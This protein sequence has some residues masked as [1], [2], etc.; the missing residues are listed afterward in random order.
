[1][2]ETEIGQYRKPSRCIPF[3]T[4]VVGAQVSGG[5]PVMGILKEVED[6]HRVES[7][8]IRFG[9]KTPNQLIGEYFKNRK[10][11]KLEGDVRKRLKGLENN[12]YVINPIKVSSEVLVEMEGGSRRG[13]VVSS[14]K[15]ELCKEKGFE[16]TILCD[17][18]RVGRESGIHK[19]SVEQY[20]DKLRLKNIE[21]ETGGKRIN[22]EVIK[23]LTDMLLPMLNVTF[24][25]SSIR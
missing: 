6:G 22:R 13:A 3:S 20:G 21:S 7:K 12:T 11:I 19:Y 5:T 14:I 8:F 17:T 4:E 18:G 15:W 9:D 2:V 24:T 25:S 1:M 16:T 23:K 10:N